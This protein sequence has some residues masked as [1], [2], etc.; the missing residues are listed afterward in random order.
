M[1]DDVNA[2]ISGFPADVRSILENIRA[3]IRKAAPDSEE[4]ISYGIPTFKRDGNY[5][6]Y[7]AGF[8]QHVSIYPILSE[9]TGLEEELAPYRS[10]KG[11]AKF[12]LN[13][14]IP[15]ALITKIV[16]FMAKEN[17]RRTA[18]KSETKRSKV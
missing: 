13:R 12:P 14:P 6:I 9:C 16:A 7:F 11:T 2:Y 18:E 17:A 4:S 15:Y 10:G 8:K 3:T 1:A 5:L